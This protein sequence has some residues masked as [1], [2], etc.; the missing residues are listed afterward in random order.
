MSSITTMASSTTNP[1]EIV[2]AINERLSMLY[3]QK[4]ITAKVPIRDTGTATMGMR[5]ARALR[6]NRNTTTMTRKM[7]MTSVRSTSFTEARIVVVRSR[8]VVMS[9]PCGMEALSDGN[10][11]LMR[12]TVSIMFAPGW[13]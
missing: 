7:E 10:W 2:R 4:Y 3:P 1:V 5:V 11:S 12:W 9:M 8:T 13:R 6:R